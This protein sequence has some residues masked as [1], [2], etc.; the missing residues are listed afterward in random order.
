M[1]L[2]IGFGHGFGA[3]FQWWIVV[4]LVCWHGGSGVEFGG[5]AMVIDDGVGLG[6][7]LW[8]AFFFFFFGCGV[9]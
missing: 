1:G 3:E 7:L 6:F 2:L 5:F 4:A 8:V 9:E